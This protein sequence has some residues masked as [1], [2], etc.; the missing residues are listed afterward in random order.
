MVHGH[1]IER[2]PGQSIDRPA[3]HWYPDP[4]LDPSAHSGREVAAHDLEARRPGLLEKPPAPNPDLEQPT[5]LSEF[6]NRPGISAVLPDLEPPH[7]KRGLRLPAFPER[8]FVELLPR[9]TT[10]QRRIHDQPAPGAAEEAKAEL[11]ESG[12]RTQRARAAHGRLCWVVHAPYSVLTHEGRSPWP[13][14]H[15]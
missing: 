9:A 13:H 7:P 1:H 4:L 2:R 5:T 8:L 11:L 10:K 14:S 3:V 6:L 12:G 15:R